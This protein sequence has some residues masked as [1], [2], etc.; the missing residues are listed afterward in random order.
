MIGNTYSFEQLGIHSFHDEEHI[1]I[2]PMFALTL[3][4]RFF[5]GYDTETAKIAVEISEATYKGLVN[6]ITPERYKE[7]Y[8]R[9]VP[10]RVRRH[11]GRDAITGSAYFL[12][13]EEGVMVEVS[14]DE[15]DWAAPDGTLRVSSH[16]W[17]EQ[18]DLENATMALIVW[19]I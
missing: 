1:P 3:D 14:Y 8:I 9:D 12:R 16:Y 2:G 4:D 7:E 10:S 13:N 6:D 17:E 19:R 11:E 18:L 15:Y 5:M